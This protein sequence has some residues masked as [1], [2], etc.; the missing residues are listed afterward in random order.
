[1]GSVTPELW[2][3]ALIALNVLIPFIAALRARDYQHSAE[4]WRA[5]LPRDEQ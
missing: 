3:A 4:F 1:V 5:R 2:L